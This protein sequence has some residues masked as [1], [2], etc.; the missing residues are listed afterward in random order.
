MRT[1]PVRTSI[2][3]VPGS[4]M[5]KIAAPARQERGWAAAMS[6]LRLRPRR[7]ATQAM[8]GAPPLTRSGW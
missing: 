2:I 4:S 7:A 3:E 1:V 8:R 5:T 6:R